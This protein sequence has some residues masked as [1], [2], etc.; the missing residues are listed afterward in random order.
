MAQAE[1]K[2][3]ILVFS[4]PVVKSIALKKPKTL[5][6]FQNIEGVGMKFF[7]TNKTD[8]NKQTPNKQTVFIFTNNH[9]QT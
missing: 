2:S 8:I 3:S 5:E 9:K 1:G 7:K 6:E 4:N